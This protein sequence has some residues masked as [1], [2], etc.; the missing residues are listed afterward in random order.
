MSCSNLRALIGVLL[1]ATSVLADS[2]WHQFKA[3]HGKNYENPLEE[4]MRR[5][6]FVRNKREVEQF[7]EEQSIEAGYELGLNHMADLTEEEISMRTSASKPLDQYLNSRNS[8]EAELFLDRVLGNRSEPL[9]ESIDW[10][11]VSGRVSS[12]KDQGDCGCCWAFSA[13]GAL[14]GQQLK[15]TGAKDLI[16]LSVQNVLDC[17][18]EASCRGGE[19]DL[20]FLQAKRLGGIMAES[21]YPYVAKKSRVCGFNKSEAVEMPVTGSARLKVGD[22]HLLQ[23]MVAKFGPVSVSINTMPATLRSYKKGIYKSADCESF[24]LCHA[25]LVV[26][27]GTENGQDYWIVV[28]IS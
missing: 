27:Y 28:S 4:N 7:N 22:E 9:P 1:V 20:G 15:V 21:A 3:K 10:R 5:A 18:K 12:V 26:G 8:A 11:Q 2:D 19:P 6:I 23:E 25:V 17:E 24:T 13:V 14:E 16:S